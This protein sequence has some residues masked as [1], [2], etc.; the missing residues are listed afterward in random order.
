MV[1]NVYLS[2]KYFLTQINL[3]VLWFSRVINDSGVMTKG[4][5]KKLF[6]DASRCVIQQC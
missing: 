6:E 2:K 3:T 4:A 1:Q 5:E